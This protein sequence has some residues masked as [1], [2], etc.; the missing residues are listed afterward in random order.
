MRINPYQSSTNANNGALA[1]LSNGSQ[2]PNVR[3]A[4]S[5][6]LADARDKLVKP[7][8][9]SGSQVS[10]S[11]AGRTLSQQA[12]AAG[13]AGEK[14]LGDLTRQTLS[15]LGITSAA[16]ALGAKI[17]FDSFS[18]SAK[19][20]TSFAA[21]YSRY[22]DRGGVTENASIEF[23]S[24]QSTEVTGKGRITTA[25]GRVFEFESQLQLQNK[26]DFSQSETRQAQA[27]S[28]NS[29]S[30]SNAQN[31]AALRGPALQIAKNSPLLAAIEDILQQIRS[32][33]SNNSNGKSAAE[34]QT[35][36]QQGIAVG[37]PNPNAQSFGDLGDLGDTSAITNDP[38]NLEQLSNGA[39][40]IAQQL[41]QLQQFSQVQGYPSPQIAVAA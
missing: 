22:A 19:S 21:S 15:S 38:F 31:I 29:E 24:E 28:A 2:S 35:P 40:K 16:D 26:T 37:E 41:K 5:Q 25:D 3:N 10:L 9:P 23:S 6:A 36:A 27:A 32:N 12:Q 18:Y 11:D 8:A 34:I 14:I 4:T 39:A 7:F 33:G 1:S 13:Q 20:S 30:T 17:E